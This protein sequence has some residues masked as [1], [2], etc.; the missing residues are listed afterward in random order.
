MISKYKIKTIHVIIRIIFK[1][2]PFSLGYKV[3]KTLDHIVAKI[4]INTMHS[5]EIFDV[6]HSVDG[7]WFGEHYSWGVGCPE[8]YAEL[9]NY[10]NIL[11]VG[12]GSALLTKSMDNVIHTDI[13]SAYEGD[14]KGQ[15][16]E[17]VEDIDAVSAVAKY[18]DSMNA[19]LAIWPSYM[20]TWQKDMLDGMLSGQT[21]LYAG[22]AEGGVTGQLAM[23]ETLKK[24]FVLEKQ[25]EM[26]STLGNSTYL[27]VWKKK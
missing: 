7:N 4:V 10:N 18:G 1:I 25:I 21:Y 3:K 2:L 14:W 13:K 24:D 22:E 6:A 5:D 16:P 19:I 20:G 15:L 8:F 27:W 23:W 9:N 26:P 12:C 11:E 17:F